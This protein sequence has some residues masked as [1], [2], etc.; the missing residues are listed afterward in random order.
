[1][2]KSV[3]LI[4]VLRRRRAPGVV[5]GEGE[6]A[7]KGEGVREMPG[8]SRPSDSERADVVG[9]VPVGDEEYGSGEGMGFGLKEK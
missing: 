9:R 8:I 1:M 2:E 7:R 4:E 5:E 3:G 6:G